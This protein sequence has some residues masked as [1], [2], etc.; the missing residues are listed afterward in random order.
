MRRECTNLDFRH[1][2]AL[3]QHLLLTHWCHPFPNDLGPKQASINISGSSINQ[4]QPYAY[5][6]SPLREFLQELV[7]LRLCLPS[8]FLSVDAFIYHKKT[9]PLFCANKENKISLILK[10]KEK[11]IRINNTKGQARNIYIKV[12][13]KSMGR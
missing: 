1:C 2:F 12:G 9:L 3:L 10:K 6:I 8:L 7:L 13:K 5:I 11:K 4:I